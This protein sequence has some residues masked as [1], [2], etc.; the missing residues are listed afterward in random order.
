MSVSNL[1]IKWEL[2]KDKN[3]KPSI[4]RG[5]INNKSVFEILCFEEE[6]EY[7]LYTFIPKTVLSNSLIGTYNKAYDA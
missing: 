6:K 1:P 2:I 3:N 5:F 4:W 7:E